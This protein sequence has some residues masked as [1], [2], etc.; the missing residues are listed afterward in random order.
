M[1]T[2][3]NKCIIQMVKEYLNLHGNLLYNNKVTLTMFFFSGQIERTNSDGR[4]S[5][6][7]PNKAER[8]IYPNGSEEVITNDGTIVRIL[9]E[10][11]E[12]VEMLSKHKKKSKPTTLR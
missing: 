6:L 4:K 8:V 5:I 3:V 1:Q 12:N 11:N 7:Y 9:F 2:G 10:D